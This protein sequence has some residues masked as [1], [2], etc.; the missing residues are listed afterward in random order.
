MNPVKHLHHHIIHMLC[1]GPRLLL[2]LLHRYFSLHLRR[3][4]PLPSKHPLNHNRGL[5][6]PPPL[7]IITLIQFQPQLLNRLNR[8]FSQFLVLSPRRCLVFYYLEVAYSGGEVLF[9]VLFFFLSLKTFI[10]I[11]RLNTSPPLLNL[12]SHPSYRQQIILIWR[13]IKRLATQFIIFGRDTTSFP[14]SFLRLIVANIE[15]VSFF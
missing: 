12:Y 2:K 8:R 4:I 11:K 7:P 13:R 9:C 1:S 14:L 15:R 10:L 6:L 3:L 5:F